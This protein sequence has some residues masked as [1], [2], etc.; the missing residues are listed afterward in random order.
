MLPGARI[1]G[2]RG[3][4]LPRAGNQLPQRPPITQLPPL[5]VGWQ[6]TLLSLRR[7]RHRRRRR[8]RRPPH[9]GLSLKFLNFRASLRAA[10]NLPR[11]TPARV[12]VWSE[13]RAA[14]TLAPP[15]RLSRARRRVGRTPMLR[16][17][18]F[19]FPVGAMRRRRC[20]RRGFW[21]GVGRRVPGGMD[22][23]RVLGR[24]K[25]RGFSSVWSP[26]PSPM[27]PVR[28][29]MDGRHRVLCGLADDVAPV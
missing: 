8:R 2:R 3:T 5:E 6:R 21:R 19:A 24:V 1:C 14:T 16:R 28:L 15:L 13:K 7:R 18:W 9:A 4:R 25:V 10:L 22:R 27:L 11:S 17:H 26:H 29:G 23:D 20:G 12:F